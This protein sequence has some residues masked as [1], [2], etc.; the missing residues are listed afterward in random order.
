MEYTCPVCGY[1]HLE[2]PAANDEICPSCGT[3]FGYHD[4]RKTH[5]EL[6]NI[7]LTNPIWHSTIDEQ[8]LNWNPYTQLAN[9][10]TKQVKT[11]S[12]SKTN[13]ITVVNL[14]KGYR[15]V[16]DSVASYSVDSH[17]EIISG[18]CVFEHA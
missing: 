14:G 1:D 4:H 12:T 7:W 11:K 13:S 6:R 16:R 15:I 9:L 17:W 2:D 3:Q 5:T 18:G 10:K 8:P